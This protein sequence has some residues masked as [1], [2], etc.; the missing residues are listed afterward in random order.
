M[1][2]PLWIHRSKY[3]NLTFP[4]HTIDIN[5]KFSLISPKNTFSGTVKDGLIYNATIFKW[6]FRIGYTFLR[7]KCTF[8]QTC[9]WFDLFLSLAVVGYRLTVISA[10]TL[11][12]RS[13]LF[14]PISYRVIFYIRWVIF[15][16]YADQNIE[17]LQFQDA[18]KYSK[19]SL[20]TSNGDSV[21][22]SSNKTDCCKTIIIKI[23]GSL[24]K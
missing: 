1:K 21:F 7:I 15:I 24:L 5:T 17:S 23:V 6:A 10:T 16:V 9:K 2:W 20:K 8:I 3:T 19:S 12:K 13:K 11:L 22:A 4:L 14:S 18:N